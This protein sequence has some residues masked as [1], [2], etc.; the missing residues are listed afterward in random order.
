MY[1]LHVGRM[2]EQDAAGI[3]ACRIVL[4]GVEKSKE[5]I[6]R[7]HQ[8]THHQSR[9]DQVGHWLFQEILPYTGERLELKEKAT[10]WS[11]VRLMRLDSELFLPS[12]SFK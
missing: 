9:K 5:N 11:S 8:M 3:S 7:I 1:V 4:K 12:H 6:K 10:V 2:L